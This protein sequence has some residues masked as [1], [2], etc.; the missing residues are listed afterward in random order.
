[1][2]NEAQETDEIM[3]VLD[4]YFAR[5]MGQKSLYLKDTVATIQKRGTDYVMYFF[6]QK[7]SLEGLD[8][9]EATRFKKFTREEITGFLQNNLLSW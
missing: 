9:K 6:D 3:S 7:P 4:N 2:G 5:N 1:M 8:I